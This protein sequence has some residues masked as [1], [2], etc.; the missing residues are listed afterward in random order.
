[1]QAIITTM[2]FSFHVE[3]YRTGPGLGTSCKTHCQN[4]FLHSLFLLCLAPADSSLSF[5]SLS[6]FFCFHSIKLCSEYPLG[7][8]LWTACC[9][10]ALLIS[11]FLKCNQNQRYNFS[12]AFDTSWPLKCLDPSAGPVPEHLSWMLLRQL[13]Q[14]HSKK[15]AV[16]MSNGNAAVRSQM[17]AW[18]WAGTHECWNT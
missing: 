5:P 18:R 15:Q 1:M 13:A 4:L 6:L 3:D 12:N 7:T 10:N 17:K 14:S 2:Y 11:M 9:T 8:V 16:L